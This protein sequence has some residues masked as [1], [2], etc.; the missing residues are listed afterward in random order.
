MKISRFASRFDTNSGIVQ[1]MEDLGDALSTN[2][3]ML[4]MGGGNPSHIP[5]VTQFFHDKMQ[6]VLDRPA[7]FAHMIGDYESPQG[8]KPFLEAITNLLNEENGWDISSKNIALTAGSQAGF[9]L[10]FNIFGGDCSDGINRQILL[11]MVPEYIGYSDVGLSDDQFVSR[12]PDIEKYDDHTFKYHVNFSELTISKNI[13]A[14]CVS[15]PTNP[16][17]NVLTDTEVEH[18]SQLAEKNGIPFIIDN[19]YG[20]PFPNII[21]S[22]ATSFWNE[23]TV[24]CMSLSKIGLPGTRTGIVIA[25]EEIIS[26]ITRMNAVLSLS[27]GSVGPT[28]AHDLVS[29]GEISRLSKTIIKPY[30]QKKS[31]LA[32]DLFHHE[33]TGIN[34]YIHKSEGAI[35]LWLW[36]PDL[37]I[38]SEVL[39]Q[40]LKKRGVLII[41]GHHFFPGL[42]S[43]WEHKNECI[44]VTYSMDENVIEQGVK[45][46]AEEVKKAYI[47]K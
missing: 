26:I 35:F 17:G 22:E 9:F 30:Y 33:L 45:I 29:S 42:E 38:T 36:F 41:S 32:I 13:G 2:K 24:L 23:N 16:T 7:E 12:K 21:F 19:A 10:L 34:Y 14:I 44:R 11:P 15:R 39:Y 27:I 25:N 5:E 47:S 20:M 28:L 4:M 8:D 3:N 6:R 46:I 37:P 1:L 40:R 31:E 18:L 43:D